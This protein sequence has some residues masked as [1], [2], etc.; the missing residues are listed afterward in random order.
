VPDGAN[1]LDGF[2]SGEFEN[3]ATKKK[4]KGTMAIMADGRIRFIP[5]TMKP[6]TFRALC[7]IAGGEKVDKLDAEAPLVAAGQ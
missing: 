1:P 2:V 5:A 7:T 3:P 6:E 4:E